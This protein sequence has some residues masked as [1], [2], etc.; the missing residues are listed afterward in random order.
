MRPSAI[1]MT[2]SRMKNLLQT[3]M[4][5]LALALTSPVQAAPIKVVLSPSIVA[6]RAG[7]SAV[8]IS[9]VRPAPAAVW[10]NGHWSRDRLGR[11]VWVA[12]YWAQPRTRKVIR[13]AHTPVGTV[14]TVKVY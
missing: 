10:I 9:V 5:A 3:T 7:P 6:P 12:G 14:R 11:R 1:P 8:R 4:A 2:E 13:T